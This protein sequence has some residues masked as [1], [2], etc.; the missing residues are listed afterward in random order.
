[1][2]RKIPDAIF[3]LSVFEENNHKKL[4]AKVNFKPLETR[5]SEN[6]SEIKAVTYHHLSIVKNQDEYSTVIIFDV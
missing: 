5:E 4:T 6:F 2:N 3:Q 1:M